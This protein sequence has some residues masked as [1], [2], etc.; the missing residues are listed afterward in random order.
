[1]KFRN[2]KTMH[3]VPVVVIPAVKACVTPIRGSSQPNAG[4]VRKTISSNTPNTNPY[5]EEVAP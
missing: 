1:M 3:M 2:P 5:S 4:E